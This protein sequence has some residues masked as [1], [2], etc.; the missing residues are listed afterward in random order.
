MDNGLGR[1]ISDLVADSFAIFLA[2]VDFRALSCWFVLVVPLFY[3]PGIFVKR[4]AQITMEK[5][6]LKFPGEILK[7]FCLKFMYV[8]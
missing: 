5:I 1:C 4:L 8:W 7:L 2:L 6:L 3:T